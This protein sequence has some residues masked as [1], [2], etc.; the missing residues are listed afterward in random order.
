MR[1][2]MRTWMLLEFLGD[3]LYHKR[4]EI[5]INPVYHNVQ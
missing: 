4:R 5:V 2:K 3:I 1:V